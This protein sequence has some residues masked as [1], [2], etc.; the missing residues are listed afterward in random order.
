[1]DIKETIERLKGEVHDWKQTKAEAHKHVVELSLKIRKLET[2]EKKL[3]AIIGE[4][5]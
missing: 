1:M 4:D 3:S 5:G 2:Q